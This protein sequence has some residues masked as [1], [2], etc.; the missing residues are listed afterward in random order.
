M[1]KTYI[2]AGLD[3]PNCAA[4]IRE[5]AAVLPGVAAAE[6]NLMR[7]TLVLTTEGEDAGLFEAVSAI[8]HRHEPDVGV[9]EALAEC[10]YLLRGLDCPHCAAKIEQEAQ[11]L[12]GVASALVNLAE[13]TLLLHCAVPVSLDTV[14]GLVHRFEPDVDVSPAVAGKADDGER[15]DDEESKARSRLLRL[16]AGAA[17]YAAAFAL[18]LYGVL[19]GAAG[20][21]VFMAVYLLLGW[22]VLWR[23]L[24]NI[25]RGQVFD[26]NFLMSVSTLG[27]FA[28]G[29][30]PEAVAVMLFYQTGEY[31]QDR[32]VSRSRRSISTL[33]GLKPDSARVLRNG[34]LA[35]ISPSEAAV[36][37][38]IVV[39][40]GERIPLDGTVVS[41]RSMLDMQALSGESVPRAACA[42]DEVLSGSISL[43]GAL[44]I[45]VGKP[46]GESTVAR[47]ISLVEN[48][49]GRKAPTENFIT[50]FA[51]WYTPAV[52]IMAAALALVP[53]LFFGQAWTEWFRRACIFLV[54]SCPCALVI[55]IPLAFFGGIGAASRHGVLVKGGNFLEALC[56]AGT[57]VFDKTG[58]LTRGVFEITSI[59][60]APG[61]PQEQLIRT[62]ALAESLSTHPIARS[63]AALAPDTNPAE[64]ESF[65]EV[66]GKGVRASAHG[67]E[68]LAGSRALMEEH[69]V[70]CPEV[71]GA[72]TR[73]F[74][75]ENGAYLGCLI[76]SDVVKPS[77]GKAIADLKELGVEKTVMLTGD[78]AAIA[79]ATAREL[80]IDEWHA[81]LLPGEKVEKLEEL[82]KHSL[83]GKKLCFV[84]DGINDAPA[85]ARADVG[86]AMGALGSD[87]AIEAADV[88]LM[89]DDPARLADA[90]T[91]ARKTRSIAMQNIAFA[92]GVKGILLILGA[93]GAATM[94]EAVFGDVGVMM[95]AVLN[96]MRMLKK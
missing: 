64:A 40:P 44:E 14:T 19:P 27:A 33:M 68:I 73:I 43:N 55:S 58:T 59:L 91:I 29:E 5:E 30:Y 3:C 79:S 37:E 88:V 23:A 61:V 76:A 36:G 69:S 51:R 25:G 84:G 81:G 31:F 18:H 45:R 57:V 21:A 94:W 16:C 46:Y 66:F 1:E 15:Q 7:Q 20:L 53:P 12:E 17:L 60:P 22:D 83:P 85:L 4:K 9:R 78:S 10:R 13:Q 95:L 39:R 38:I 32:A 34:T 89:S 75:A 11:K 65:E 93:L 49:A 48:A 72:G 96:S 54:I 62:A 50:A 56:H 67:S 8:V 82:D 42:G 70:A 6:L 41:G 86:I 90:I 52:V 28:I 63:V 77:A 92:L 2:L 35:E 26:E 24:R 87:A 47:I 80:G 71:P 74:I